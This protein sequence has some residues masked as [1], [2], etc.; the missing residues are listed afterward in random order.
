MYACPMDLSCSRLGYQ[1]LHLTTVGSLELNHF[2][3]PSCV[4]SKNFDKLALGAVSQGGCGLFAV[5]AMFLRME[6]WLFSLIVM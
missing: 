5:M 1:E 4:I 6:T 3:F 2:V